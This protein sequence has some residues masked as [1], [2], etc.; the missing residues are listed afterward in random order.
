LPGE[1]RTIEVQV[2]ASLVTEKRLL[3]KLDGWNLKAF[4][5]HELLVP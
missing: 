1:K 5:E 2:D 3:F 4:Q